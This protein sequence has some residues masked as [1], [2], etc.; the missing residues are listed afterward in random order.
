MKADAAPAGIY[1]IRNRSTGEVYIGQSVNIYQR[2]RQHM[3]HLQAGRHGNRR[4]QEAWKTFGSR[5]FSWSILEVLAPNGNLTEAEWRWCVVMQTQ[6][7]GLYN[8]APIRPS[9]EELARAAVDAAIERLALK[10]RRYLQHMQRKRAATEAR[11]AG[12][13]DLAAKLERQ[14]EAYSAQAPVPV[15][16]D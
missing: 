4:L 3:Q 14:A 11:A 10:G 13:H 8:S 7:A 2:V 9:V 6:S 1:R 16:D 12:K 5:G 15:L